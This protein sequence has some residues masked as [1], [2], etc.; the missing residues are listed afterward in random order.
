MFSKCYKL[1]EIKGINKFNT[2]GVINM[3]AMFQSCY[4]LKYL[5][6]SNLN[7]SNTSDLSYMFTQ[8]NKL[9]YLNI[10]KFKPYDI[11]KNMFLF[12][13]NNECEYIAENETFVALFN[14]SNN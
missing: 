4:E 10:S 1:R 6:L 13:T 9:K 8:W 2:S 7:T 14:S 11:T 5:D 12:D 3:R